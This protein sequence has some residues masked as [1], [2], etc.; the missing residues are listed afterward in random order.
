MAHRSNATRKPSQCRRKAAHRVRC[1]SATSQRLRLR[2]NNAT[3]IG[4][5]ALDAARWK[6]YHGGTA[7]DLWIDPN[8]TG[9]YRRLISLRGNLIW[10]LWL[11]NRVY[12]VSDHDGIANIYSCNAEGDDLQR[13]T[14]E[15]EYYARYPSTDGRLIVYG[16]GAELKVLDTVDNSVRTIEVATP[17][18]APQTVRRFVESSERLEHFAPSPDGTQI[19]L[20]SRGQP[21]AMP[22][23]EEAV[24]HHGRGSRVRY[25]K[26]SAR[27]GRHVGA[28]ASK[29]E[30]D[31]G[32][33]HKGKDS[34]R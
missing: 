30:A 18:T 11:G 1:A 6:R 10:P 13:H 19:A 34:A 32:T 23:W 5:N 15:R 33:G 7:G 17:S 29:P 14:D 8:G 21:Y 2:T 31:D 3:L 4:R 16:A 22:L 12:F 20:V 28:D 25:R 9:T 27:A 24:T 26:W